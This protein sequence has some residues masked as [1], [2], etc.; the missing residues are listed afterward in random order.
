MDALLSYKISNALTVGVS[1][2]VNIKSQAVETE[3]KQGSLPFGVSLD[4]SF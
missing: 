4:L 1:T 2:G 3:R